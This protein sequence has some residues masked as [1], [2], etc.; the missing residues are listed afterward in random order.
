[1]CLFI[2]NQLIQKDFLNSSNLNLQWINGGWNTSRLGCAMVSCETGTQVTSLW[3]HTTNSAEHEPVGTAGTT[4]RWV[5]EIF[6]ASLFSWKGFMHTDNV[7]TSFIHWI[8]ASGLN[9]CS[10]GDAK[11]QWKYNSIPPRAMFGLEARMRGWS[12]KQNWLGIFQQN[13]SFIW[14]GWFIETKSVC[15]NMRRGLGWLR[16]TQASDLSCCFPSISFAQWILNYWYK[17]K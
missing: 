9:K 4:D 3:E 2:Q 16:L 7:L 10:Q 12:Y 1:M 13:R 17:M 14:H 11:L 15:R 8:E 6:V 5:Q